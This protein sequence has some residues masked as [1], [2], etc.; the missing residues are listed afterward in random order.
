MPAI[1]DFTRRGD[2]FDHWSDPWGERL[3]DDKNELPPGLW[4]IIPSDVG[5]HYYDRVVLLYPEDVHSIR[6][7]KPWVG[8]VYDDGNFPAGTLIQFPQVEE[9][10]PRPEA[11]EVIQHFP[12]L[13]PEIIG[14]YSIDLTD[15]RV[16]LDRFIQIQ[17][18]TEEIWVTYDDATFRCRISRRDYEEYLDDIYD[19]WYYRCAVTAEESPAGP[20]GQAIWISLEGDSNPETNLTRVL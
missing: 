9:L 3:I 7:G 19:D 11:K 5:I 6:R 15:R 14:L 2:E 12:R 1:R 4:R 13:T 8:V 20:P 18:C 16:S 10:P 17:E